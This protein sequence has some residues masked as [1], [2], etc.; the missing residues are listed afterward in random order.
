MNRPARESPA[1]SKPAEAEAWL[2]VPDIDS[3]PALEKLLDDNRLVRSGQTEAITNTEPTP[4]VSFEQ[5]WAE[6][7]QR[8]PAPRRRARPRWR[9]RVVT[10]GLALLGAVIAV[11][12]VPR[13]L[14]QSPALTIRV[15]GKERIST[16]T[17][18]K[19]V[20]AALREHHVKLGP[21]DRVTPSLAAKVTDGSTVN[22]FRSFPVV[23]DLDGGVRS[24]N[25]TWPKPE[26]LARQLGLDPARTAIVTGPTRLTEGASVVLRT[27]HDVTIS[28]D[29]TQQTE[30][31]PALDVGEFLLHNGV[32]L[33]PGDKITPPADTRLADGMTVAVAR[34]LSDA[35]QADEPLPPP[36][37]RRDDP[38][39]PTGQER[40]IQ[41]GVPG[42]QRITYQITKLGGQEV[43]R[44]AVSKVPI[45]PPTPTVVAVGTAPPD[46]NTG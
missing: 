9:R 10:L 20:G 27:M 16:E 17:D 34:F 40:E 42:V 15:D 28:V 25:T 7:R 32:V 24:F 11:V 33:G 36:T 5:R 43:A 19:T 30:R 35:T 41:A 45:Q 26:Q 37:I 31:S 38:G 22:V 1:R 2:P 6:F 4:V 3:S 14:P 8:V 21:D 18:A 39:L 13:L 12:A 29:G 44:A 23:V 46:T